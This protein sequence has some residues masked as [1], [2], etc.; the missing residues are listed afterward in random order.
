MK[1]HTEWQEFLKE[2]INKDYYKNL[3][4][5]LNNEEKENKVIYPSKENIFNALSISPKDIKV[6]ILGQDPYHGVNQAHGYSFSVKKGI[7]LPPSLKNIYKEIENEFGY[8]MSKTNGDL[9]PW[10][11]QGVM[12]LN[13]ILTV[14]KGEASSHKNQGWE[15]FT[16]KIISSLA[17]NYNNIVFMLW[18]A[19]AKGKTSLAKKNN[20]LIL[21][22][23][24][25]SPFSVHSGFFGNNHFKLANEFLKA[26]NKEEI[27]WQIK[28]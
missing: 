9:T 3:V 8:K 7:T 13:S 17:S 4:S 24:H 10:V 2:E 18:G 1:A 27:N 19:Y 6:V 25:P 21:T 28:D 22:S 15:I 26:N 16:D 23:P 14:R 12:L 20:N 11:N 5:F